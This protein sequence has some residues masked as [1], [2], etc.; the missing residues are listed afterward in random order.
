MLLLVLLLATA[1]S[2][3]K[4]PEQVQPEEVDQRINTMVIEPDRLPAVLDA[5]STLERPL[6]VD[7]ELTFSEYE[8]A[9]FA[10]VEC[11]EEA[12]FRIVHFPD[13]VVVGSVGHTNLDSQVDG[14]F[15]TRRGKYEYAANA[16]GGRDPA[17]DG[18]KVAECKAISATVEFLWTE[19]LA[20]TELELQARRNMMSTCLRSNGRQIPVNPAQS[21]LDRIAF[22]P[23]GTPTAFQHVPRDY[24]E[25]E[26]QTAAELGF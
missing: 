23:D 15:L 14:P 10:S 20:P 24:L 25:C 11:L 5:A 3:P 6:L 1:C 4:A 26:R 9:V 17:K 7:G 2:G 12:G 16:S 19:H 22:P 18:L 8:A 21:D 13:S